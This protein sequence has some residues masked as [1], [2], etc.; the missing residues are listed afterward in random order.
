M[1][2]IE[3]LTAGQE[4]AMLAY[5]DEW[6]A[7]G[8]STEPADRAT[9]ERVLYAMY[10]A[11]GEKQPYVWW[12]DGPAAGSLVRTVLRANLGDNLGDNLRA[13]L[14]ANLWANLRA[15]LWANLRDNLRANL[16]A[17]LEYVDTWSWGSLDAYW[18]AHY[19][20]PHARLHPMHTDEQMVILNGWATIAR[21]AFWWY[22]FEGVCFVC[23]RPTEIH[24]DERASLHNSSGPSVAF[25][26]GWKLYHV[27]GVEVPGEIIERPDTI[28]VAR[29]D[30]E[31]NAEVRRVMIE[32]YGA[33]RFLVDG[34]AQ[35][36]H[37][38][39]YGD[40]YRREIV[41]DEPLVMVQ[42]IN[43]TAEPD[44][45]NKA[46]WLRVPPDIQTAEA[47]VAW[48]FDYQPGEFEFVAQS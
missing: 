48:T 33:D 27:H 41:D 25:A 37:S 29:I 36:V 34:G 32:L 9:T 13:N 12:C 45:S 6:L 35:L 42:V 23:D 39:G 31:R 14:R 3:N 43:S 46:Y 7:I 44:G 26:D 22:T 8:R 17:N 28:T 10:T 30:A 24:K 18:I 20:F 21:S 1:K 38:D 15:N 4:R 11:I 19:L 5:R 40:L 16:G 47:A 2:R